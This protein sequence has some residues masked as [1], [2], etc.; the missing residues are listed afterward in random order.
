MY[1]LI[2]WDTVKNT[3][4]IMMTMIESLRGTK[5]LVFDGGKYSIRN[6]TTLE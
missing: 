6:T 4:K 2:I 5:D 1:I 3:G